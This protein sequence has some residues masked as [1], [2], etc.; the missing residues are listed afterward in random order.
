MEPQKTKAFSVRNHGPRCYRVSCNG[1]RFG[2]IRKHGR[3]WHAEIRDTE[4]GSL[5]RFAGVWRTRRDAT[6]E[7]ESILSRVS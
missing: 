1:D 3:E 5:I 6:E 4:S 7:I 2:Q